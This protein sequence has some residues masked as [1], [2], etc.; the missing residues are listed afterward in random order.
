MQVQVHSG[1]DVWEADTRAPDFTG[2]TAKSCHAK[3]IIRPFGV[4]VMNVHHFE[5][6]AAGARCCSAPIKSISVS[7]RARDLDAAPP[8]L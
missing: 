1:Y 7:P 2:C 8:L 3:S 6:P 4:D 5:R